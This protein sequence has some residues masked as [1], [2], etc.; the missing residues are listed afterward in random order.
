M[1]IQVLFWTL[2]CLMCSWCLWSPMEC[3]QTDAFS[4]KPKTKVHVR[5]Q[6][7]CLEFKTKSKASKHRHISNN[8]IQWQEAHLSSHTEAWEEVFENNPNLRRNF[9]KNEQSKA[10]FASSRIN[11]GV[12]RSPSPNQSG[13]TSGSPKRWNAVFVIPFCFNLRNSVLNIFCIPRR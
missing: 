12:A 8:R 11:V 13:M 3:V 6:N 9:E 10:I 5:H 1:S 2:L 7:A 4:G